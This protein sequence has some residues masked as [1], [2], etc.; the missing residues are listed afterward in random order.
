L[1]QGEA[2]QAF[3]ASGGAASDQPLASWTGTRDPCHGWA[4]VTCS[5]FPWPAVTGLDLNTAFGN[6]WF[7]NVTGSIAALAPLAMLERTLNL[8]N[9]KVFG[10]VSALVGLVRLTHLDL[11]ATAVTGN[12]TAL[13]PLVKLTELHLDYTAVMGD[14]KS[15]AQLVK[16]THLDLSATAVIGDV[17]GL[18]PLVQLTE[19]F[20]FNTAVAGDVGAL[21]PLA[22]L[23]ILNLVNTEVAVARGDTAVILCCCC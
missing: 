15:L 19:L 7:A 16:L 3:K 6:Y 13:A 14:V 8:R 20:L 21:A 12:I 5:G 18:A 17:K 1:L 2:L 9:I 22:G 10:N 23:T 11:G 4:G